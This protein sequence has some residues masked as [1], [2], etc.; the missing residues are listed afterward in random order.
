MTGQF[1]DRL[2]ILTLT[3]WKFPFYEFS[4]VI[5][6]LWFA[7]K[8]IWKHSVKWNVLYLFACFFTHQDALHTVYQ[9]SLNFPC[10]PQLSPVFWVNRTA[11][12][13]LSWSVFL[14]MLFTYPDALHTV[15]QDSLTFPYVPKFS[16]AIVCRWIFL[17]DTALL[18]LSPALDTLPP[19]H[20]EGP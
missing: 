8:K 5:L 12:P 2:F 7:I 1:I 10:L 19:G 6:F 17:T 13:C 20:W 16:P 14:W 3:Y 18:L 4:E 15:H 9:D 11:S